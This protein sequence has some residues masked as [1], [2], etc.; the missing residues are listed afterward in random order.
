V[1]RYAAFLRGVNL[2]ARTVKSADLLAVFERLGL[3]GVKTLLASGNVMFDSDET[4]EALRPRIETAL[5][6]KFGFAVGTVLRT[7]GE[8][9]ALVAADPFAGKTETVDLKLYVTL[10]A[11]PDAERLPLP[12]ALPGDF[13]VVNCTKS[14]IFHEAYRMPSGRYGAGATLIGK[15]LGKTVLWTN[16]NWNTIVKAAE[17]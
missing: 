8:L 6:Q 3:S 9:R 10:L 1:T 12:C 16:R 13:E 11:T 2:G 7:Q 5:E 15:G 4:A 14:E 17:A